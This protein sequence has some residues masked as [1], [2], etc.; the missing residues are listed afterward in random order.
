MSNLTDV[1]LFFF[2]LQVGTKYDQFSAFSR[3]E[4]DEIT[5]QVSIAFKSM[6]RLSKNG[7]ADVSVSDIYM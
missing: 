5:R 1:V 4:Q 6:R 7:K 2:S 3:E